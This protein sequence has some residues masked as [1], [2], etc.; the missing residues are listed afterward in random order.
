MTV[1]EFF[2]GC[3]GIAVIVIVTGVSVAW[4]LIL[5]VTGLLYFCGMLR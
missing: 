3:L 1:Q 4:A 2:A 5:P